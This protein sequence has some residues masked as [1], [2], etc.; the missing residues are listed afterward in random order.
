LQISSGF[1]FQILPPSWQSNCLP[2]SWL[3]HISQQ[4]ASQPE[5]TNKEVADLIM[6]STLLWDKSRVQVLRVDWNFVYVNVKMNISNAISNALQ[7]VLAIMLL[8]TELLQ[9]SL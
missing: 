1:T 9:K 2:T 8:N 3:S 5:E 4:E 7:E 6:N